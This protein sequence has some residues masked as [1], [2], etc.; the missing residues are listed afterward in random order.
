MNRPHP[1]SKL[2]KKYNEF[3]QDKILEIFSLPVP[4]AFCFRCRTISI[5]PSFT[6]KLSSRRNATSRPRLF[7][8]WIALSTR[9]ISNQWIVQLVSVILIRW[10]VIYSVD[11][12]IQR[13]NDWSQGNKRVKCPEGGGVVASPSTTIGE[14]GKT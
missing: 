8:G 6:G 4:N 11:S 7:K 1:L 9:Y 14:S 10:I 2:R 3:Y 5:T 12:D 13:L